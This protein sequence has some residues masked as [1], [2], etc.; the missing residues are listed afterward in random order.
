MLCNERDYVEAIFSGDL[1]AD[2]LERVRMPKEDH[3]VLY[4]FAY[5]ILDAKL[6]EPD[7]LAVQ[8][9]VMIHDMLGARGIPI[10]VV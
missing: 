7:R 5:Q 4:A 6:K 3:E 10:E 2:H 1:T 8:V 9:F